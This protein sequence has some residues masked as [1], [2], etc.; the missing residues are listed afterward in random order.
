MYQ[1]AH[2]DCLATMSDISILLARLYLGLPFAYV[3][4][5]DGELGAAMRTSGKVPN[6]KTHYSAELKAA[7]RRAMN[8]TH[9]YLYTGL[10]CPNEFKM[11]HAKALELVRTEKARRT[12]AT[13]FINGN[14][15]F[16]L[17]LLPC[18]IH[19]RQLHRGSRLHMLVSTAANMTLFHS[20]TEL[21]PYTVIRTPP[22]DSVRAFSTILLKATLFEPGDIVVVESGVLGRLLVAEWVAMRP[23]TTFLEIGSFFDPQLGFRKIAYHRGGWAPGCAERS[24]QHIRGFEPMKQCLEDG[25]AFTLK[26]HESRNSASSWFLAN[27]T[28]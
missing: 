9:P 6:G 19:H 3:H 5:N 1:R 14:Y 20:Q 7:V 12:T 13:I 2:D 21:V 8:A 17:P 27:W 22:T 16:V 24:D 10:P 18:I 26:I 25:L 15:K 28:G 11:H 23:D 4:F